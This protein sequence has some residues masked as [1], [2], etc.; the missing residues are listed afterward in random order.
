MASTSTTKKVKNADR[1]IALERAVQQL[2][3][4]LEKLNVSALGL[5]ELKTK[6]ET[7]EAVNEEIEGRLGKLELQV[8]ELAS[9]LEILSIKFEDFNREWPTLGSRNKEN[10]TTINSQNSHGDK[11]GQPVQ[12]VL[13]RKIVVTGDSLARGVGHKLRDQCGRMV[14]VKAVGGAKLSEVADKI[15]GMGKDE[16]R[17]LVVI[18]GS[19]SMDEPTAD[20]LGNFDKIIDAGKGS[21]DDVVIVGLVKRYD[22]GRNYGCKRI[23]VN[24]KLKAMCREK[25]VKYVEY[26]P[27]RSRVH[28]DGI[29]LNFRGQY[30]L[31]NKLSP[32]VNAFLV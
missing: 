18:A 24:S 30:E 13:E 2:T 25:G 32:F 19:N 9:K 23:L 20:L 10:S 17:Q 8:G 6:V 16:N 3:E 31:R 22:T 28:R 5:H 14:D 29:H 21:S 1:I 27:E 4:K 15:V 12:S 7:R 11:K 26:E